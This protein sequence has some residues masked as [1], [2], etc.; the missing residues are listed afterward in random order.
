MLQ[1]ISH[2]AGWDSSLG[3]AATSRPV[4][5]ATD[6]KRVRSIGEVITGKRK[7]TYSVKSCP[8]ATSSTK[9]TQM[10]LPWIEP[11]QPRWEAGDEPPERWRGLESELLTSRRS[12]PL[13]NLGEVSESEFCS[14]GISFV[15]RDGHY[16][17]WMRYVVFPSVCHTR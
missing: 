3:T 4:V 17:F 8:S 15:P 10:T 12:K 14:R 1:Y 7:P 11:R 5:P 2:R 6:D 9:K 16:L 13:V